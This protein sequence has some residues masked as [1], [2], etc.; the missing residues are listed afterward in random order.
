MSSTWK[1]L[2][3]GSLVVNAVLVVAVIALAVHLSNSVDA[4]NQQAAQASRTADAALQQAV[5][6]QNAAQPGAGV[7]EELPDVI[8]EQGRVRSQLNALCAV[9]EGPYPP[10]PPKSQVAVLVRQLDAQVCA[11]P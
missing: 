11:A 3:I 9:L 2:V 10:P 4:S 8:S 5:D 7:A 6:A 1:T